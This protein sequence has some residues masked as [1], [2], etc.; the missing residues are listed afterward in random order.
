MGGGGKY[1]AT[2]RGF[3]VHHE[4]F[5]EN[6]K[7]YSRSHFV[8]GVELTILL[9]AYEIY[10]AVATDSTSYMLLTSSMWFLVVSWMFAPF[11]SNPSGF[12]WQ[13]IVEDWE[14]WTK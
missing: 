7:M 4:K 2:R 14:D 8:K 5:A 3:V 11:L 10:G 13:K 12:E 9:I 1:R 6:Y